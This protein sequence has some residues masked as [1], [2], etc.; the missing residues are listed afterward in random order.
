M[1]TFEIF[2]NEYSYREL[3][4]IC[5]HF[6]K[7]YNEMLSN[8]IDMEDYFQTMCINL[9]KDNNFNED[10]ASIRTYVNI[11]IKY[12][13]F[14]LVR[15]LKAKKRMINY[16]TI[17]IETPVNATNELYLADMLEDENNYFENIETE[18]CLDKICELIPKEEQKVIF[19][20]HIQGYSFVEIGKKVK[21]TNKQVNQI[22]QTV[23]KR[24]Q[25]MPYVINNVIR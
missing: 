11:K 8:I 21:L 5:N 13:T 23:K 2:C 25:R 3:R 1:N 15:D 6:Y 19:K 9:Y 12:A 16:N 17:S 4:G 10:R 18:N 24:L 20:M 22:F 7:Q 14:T